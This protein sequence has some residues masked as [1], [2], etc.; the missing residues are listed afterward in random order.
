MVP[1]RVNQL[2]PAPPLLPLLMALP[3]GSLCL[4]RYG[5]SFMLFPTRGLWSLT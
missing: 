4:G 3:M 1:R 2:L 5:Y